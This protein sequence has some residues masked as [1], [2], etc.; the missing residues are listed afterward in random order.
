M[1]NFITFKMLVRHIRP[2]HTPRCSSVRTGERRATAVIFSNQSNH[3]RH[4]PSLLLNSLHALPPALDLLL[5]QPH[6]VVARADG[7]HIPAQ[8]PARAPGD[9]IKVERR[10]HPLARGIGGGRGPDAHG[11]VLGGGRDVGLGQDGGRPG[12]VAHPVSVAGEGVD[13][14]VALAVGTVRGEKEES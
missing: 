9:S 4:G 14:L 1:V 2:S 11:A 13:D 10:R 3:Q 7:K 5:V 6:A 12:H 8:A